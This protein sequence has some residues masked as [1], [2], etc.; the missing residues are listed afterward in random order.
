MQFKYKRIILH[1]CSY[2]IKWIINNDFK[3]NNGTAYPDYVDII[4]DI[5]KQNTCSYLKISASHM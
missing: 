2:Q 5:I 1:D 4:K 3:T